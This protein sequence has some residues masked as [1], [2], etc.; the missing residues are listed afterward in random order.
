MRN[1]DVEGLDVSTANN[2]QKFIQDFIKTRKQHFIPWSLFLFVILS[3][4]KTF[5][6]NSKS[7]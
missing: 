7:I 5:N 4:F 6:L 2:L 3:I 1:F